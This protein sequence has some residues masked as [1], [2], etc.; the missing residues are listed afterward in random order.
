VGD[1]V[2]AVAAE[3]LDAAEEALRLIEVKYDPLPAVFDAEE[4]MSFSPPFILHSELS[5]YTQAMGE[6]R[7]DLD[8]ERPNVNYHYKLRKGDINKGFQEAEWV[9]EEKYSSAQIQHSA[10]EPHCAVA[11]PESGGGITIFAG[12]QSIHRTK[13]QISDVFEKPPSSVRII[14]PYVGGAFGSKITLAPSSFAAL[15]AFRTGRPVKVRYTREEVFIGSV[16]RGAMVVYIKDG[17][18]RDGTLVAREIKIV[19]NSGAY[20]ESSGVCA[21]TAVC[22]AM[23]CYRVPNIKVD[24]YAVYTNLPVSGALRGLHCHLTTMAAECQLDLIAEKLNLDP[25]AIRKKNLL[26]EG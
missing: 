18:K 20:A 23:A 16:T 11:Q 13:V 12:K 2:A 22:G 10:L 3:S 7:P 19:I 1:P 6:Y 21:Y 15:L 24:S 26:H 17:V 9:V 4:A 14:S 8:P 5:A 25:I